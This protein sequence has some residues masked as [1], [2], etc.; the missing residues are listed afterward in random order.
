M[1][2][3]KPIESVGDYIQAQSPEKK[4]E[5]ERIRKTVKKFYPDTEEL[6]SYGMPAF[7]YHQRV[8][9]YY[10]AHANHLSIYPAS[11][12]MIEAVGK[13]L[14][15]YRVSK[16]TLKFTAE[17]PLPDKLLEA[18]IKFQASRIDQKT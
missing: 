17:E 11:D 1:K 16:G 13:D 9:I 6:M 2:S 5:L 14:E 15:K 12:E 4:A 7:K 8:L 3:V 10:A 18:V